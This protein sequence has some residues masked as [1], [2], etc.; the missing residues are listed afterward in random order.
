MSFLNQNPFLAFNK[1]QRSGLLIL[2]VLIVVV[3]V[4]FFWVNSQTDF[5]PNSK[6]PQDLSAIQKQIDSLKSIEP[7]KDT[8]YPFNPNYITDYKGYLLGMSLEEIDR[9]HAFRDLG[10][11]VNSADEFQEVTQVSDSLIDVISPSFKFPEWV[12]KNTKISS[13]SSQLEKNAFE[14]P[15]KKVDLN[16][17]D[18]EQLKKING[19]GDKL[20]ER[21]ISFRN[22]LGGFLVD[23]QLYDVYGL[24]SMVVKRALD[25]FTVL[26]PPTIEKI[27]L[28]EAT[29]D[30]LRS[31]VY[32]N[33]KLAGKILDYRRVKGTIKSLEELTKIEDFPAD[34]LPSI[35]LYLYLK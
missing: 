30:Q 4:A 12:N 22:R 27:E 20:S 31:I 18:V 21:I 16:T 19:I 1:H 10:K 15:I 24:D 14:K 17:A 26:T 3:Q 5:Q 35:A 2:A 7:P 13:T 11:Y 28:N 25:K 29:Y 8:I 23:A 9:L 6:H 33:G 34:R 32:I